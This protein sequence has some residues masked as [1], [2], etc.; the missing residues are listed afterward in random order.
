MDRSEQIKNIQKEY[1]FP[2]DMLKDYICEN[3]NIKVAEF[4]KITNGID[5]EI[6][7]IGQYIVKIRR[8]T[9][10]HFSCVK[11]AA[12]KCR[13]VGVKVPEIIYCGKISDSDKLLDIMIEEKIQGTPLT[14]DLYEEAGA[15][16][17]KIHSIEVNGFWRMHEDGKFDF[18]INGIRQDGLQFLFE[19]KN[20]VIPPVLCHGDYRCDH[21]LCGENNIN[22]IIDFGDFNGGSVYYDLAH[23]YVYSADKKYFGRFIKGYGEI[24]E[25]ALIK[26]AVEFLTWDLEDSKK[27]GNK[28]NTKIIERRLHEMLEINRIL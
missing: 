22:G 14:P 16:L 6:Y 8:K 18:D 2:L 10:N 25:K 21:I 4:K 19:N 9:P 27:D 12:D 7:D 1:N 15:E 23:F 3:T 5:S 13:E 17:R 28:N 26:K 20:D 11:W 24:D